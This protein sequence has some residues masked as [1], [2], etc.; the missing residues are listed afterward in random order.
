MWRLWGRNLCFATG[1][2]NFSR[3]N[4]LINTM[5]LTSLSA[6]EYNEKVLMIGQ[7][8]MRLKL[9]TKKNRNSFKKCVYWESEKR[10]QKQKKI[11]QQRRKKKQIKQKLYSTSVGHIANTITSVSF[12]DPVKWSLLFNSF[13]RRSKQ[14]PVLIGNFFGFVIN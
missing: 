10:K 4:V 9:F 3:R 11:D 6:L 7:Q 2:Y 8:M 14:D 12:E 1:S 5:Y 13:D